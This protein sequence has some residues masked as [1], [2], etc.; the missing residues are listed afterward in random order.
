MSGGPFYAFGAIDDVFFY[1]RALSAAEILQIYEVC[2]VDRS[3]EASS[4]TLILSNPYN[5]RGPIRLLGLHEL[6]DCS[7]TLY[8]SAGVRVRAINTAAQPAVTDGLAWDGLTDAGVKAPS[9]LYFL[10]AE[11]SHETTIARLVLLW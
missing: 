2:S 3:H 8:S 9:G 10:R 7:V 5:P 4:L 1:S 11:C 6:S